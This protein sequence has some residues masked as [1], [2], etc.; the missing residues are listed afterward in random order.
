MTTYT[1]TKPITV[2]QL[3]AK[4]L[5]EGRTIKQWANDNGYDF[6][7]VY[8]VVGGTR[9]GIYGVGHEIAVRL[10]IKEGSVTTTERPK[11]AA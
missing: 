1:C 4:M 3:K 11:K 10:G 6:N 7:T 8:K 9:K 2:E 5:L